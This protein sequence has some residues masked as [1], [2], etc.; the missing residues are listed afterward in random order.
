MSNETIKQIAE[1]N[2][3]FYEYPAVKEVDSLKIIINPNDPSTPSDYADNE[4]LTFD[5]LIQIDVWG[6]N[7][8]EVETVANEIRDSLWN[9]IG[10]YQISGPKGY[11]D[12]VFHDARRYRGKFY[13][14]SW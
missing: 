4:W 11:T 10:F 12:G 7:R 5:F 2:I 14:D 6:L 9:E 1:N 8:K 3:K 13:K